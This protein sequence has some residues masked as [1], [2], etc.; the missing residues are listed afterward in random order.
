MA[1]LF[2]MFDRPNVLSRVRGDC[3][4]DGYK[5]WIRT[6]NFSIGSESIDCTKYLDSSDPGISQMAANGTTVPLASLAEVDD[7]GSLVWRSNFT[8]V[9]ITAWQWAAGDTQPTIAF[10]FVY[11]DVV[12][13]NYHNAPSVPTP[14][15]IYIDLDEDE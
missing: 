13:N 11:D 8:K 14:L 12:A 2:A 7:D 10:S 4:I 9:M 6:R 5:G 1:Y 15:E 3:T